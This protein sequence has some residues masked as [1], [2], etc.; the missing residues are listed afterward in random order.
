MDQNEHTAA[1]LVNNESFI[2]YVKK[3][4]QQDIQY[5]EARIK[6]NSEDMDIINEAREIILLLSYS[7][8]NIEE[9]FYTGLKARIDNTIA[10]QSPPA[11]IIRRISFIKI[12]AAAILAITLTFGG[13]YYYYVQKS[14]ELVTIQVAYGK[15][16][17]LWLPDSSKVILNANSTLKFAKK[18]NDTNREVWLSGEG[19]FNISHVYDKSRAPLKFIVNAD[20][21]Q[22]KVLGTIFNV[23][24]GSDSTAVTLLQGKVKLNAV[25]DSTP[26]SPGEYALYRKDI[27]PIIKTT[28]DTSVITAWVKCKYVFKSAS[29]KEICQ[30]LTAYY[31]SR[32]VVNN[33]ALSRK[34]ISGS[35]DLSSETVSVKTLEVLLNTNIRSEGRTYYIGN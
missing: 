35:L 1:D 26:L 14:V 23:H 22:I 15:T 19:F 5:W 25:N 12:A 11:A 17:T 6:S 9:S 4:N 27:H 13:I 34:Q 32:Y 3:A 28:A 18:W 8:T 24:T 16:R 2:N 33:V 7:K 31:G 20:H 21:C 30:K 10:V 29:V